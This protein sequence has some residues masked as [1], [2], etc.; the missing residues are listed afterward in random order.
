MS[1]KY[2]ITLSKDNVETIKF[3]LDTGIENTLEVMLSRFKENKSVLTDELETLQ[4]LIRTRDMF[5]LALME[6]ETNDT[7]ADFGKREFT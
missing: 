5:S 2:E 7:V 3:C 6:V 1:K 4:K